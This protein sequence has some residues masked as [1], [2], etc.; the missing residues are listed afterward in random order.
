MD[1]RDNVERGAHWNFEI[2]H[3]AGDGTKWSTPERLTHD[4][5]YSFDPVVV[6][7]SRD[8]LHVLWRDKRDFNYE[9]YYKRYLSEQGKEFVLKPVEIQPTSKSAPPESQKPDTAVPIPTSTATNTP[10]PKKESPVRV[11]SPSPTAAVYTPTFTMTK[12]SL[13]TPVPK[14]GSPTPTSTPAD[15]PTFTSSPMPTATPTHTPTANWVATL[16]AARQKRKKSVTKP[17][18]GKK[19]PYYSRPTF[20]P[21]KTWTPK[22]RFTLTPTVTMTLSAVYTATIVPTMHPTGIRNTTP[23]EA[24]TFEFDSMQE[25]EEDLLPSEPELIPL[26]DA[27]AIPLPEREIDS[28][29]LLTPTPTPAN[30]ATYTQMPSPGM[31][32]A[33]TPEFTPA[34]TPTAEPSPMISARAMTFY[35]HQSLDRNRWGDGWSNGSV[36]PGGEFMSEAPPKQPVPSEILLEILENYHCY[37]D[38]PVSGTFEPG[39]FIAALWVGNPDGAVNGLIQLHLELTNETGTLAVDLGKN[40]LQCRT[41]EKGAM[42]FQSKPFHIDEQLIVD[43]YRFKLTITPIDALDL[44]LYIYWD[45]YQNGTSRLTTPLFTPS[46]G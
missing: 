25:S 27:S 19:A 5:A 4:N 2:Y 42:Q 28:T 44:K 21:T 40:F 6:T 46:S 38:P 8:N 32:P 17:D 23:T 34:H 1:S 9:I 35:F 30:T 33:I 36:H 29:R 3:I 12:Y 7:D 20:P 37:S 16:K 13:P 39:D 14:V 26:P 22:P 45:S 43:R 15:T 10:T 18:I 24:P 11:F 31:T 41:S